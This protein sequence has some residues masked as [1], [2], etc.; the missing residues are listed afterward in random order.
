[1]PRMRWELGQGKAELDFQEGAFSSLAAG[2]LRHHH[3]VA[4]PFIF[5]ALLL[6]WFG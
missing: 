1:M 6:H 2:D 5:P 4:R 3:L